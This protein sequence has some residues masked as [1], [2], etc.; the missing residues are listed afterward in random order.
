MN[1]Q[2]HDRETG[3]NADAPG[4]NATPDLLPTIDRLMARIVD[5]EA[6]EHDWRTFETLAQSDQRA[7]RALACMQRDAALV[8]EAVRPALIAADRVRLPW[9]VETAGQAADSPRRT[10]GANR[11]DHGRRSDA[12]RFGG[13]AVAAMVGLAWLGSSLGLR[14]D[15]AGPTGPIAGTGPNRASVLPTNWSIETPEDAVRAYL[16]V[17]ARSGRVIGEIPDRV[18]VRTTP[19]VGEN[20]AA[21]VE[22]VYIRQFV[23]RTVI[24]DVLEMGTDELGRPV[25]VRV[26]LPPAA[27]QATWQ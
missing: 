25:P 2:N 12:R 22:V 15:G 3:R 9:S 21:Q 5:G 23:E 18:I 11:A 26:G 6:D 19:T 7:W 20:R 4:A 16:D 8:A 17:G 1:P 10:R 14:T 27:R 13:W 24:T